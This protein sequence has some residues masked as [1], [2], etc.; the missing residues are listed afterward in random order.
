MN[1]I[2]STKRPMNNAGFSLV[3]L[4]VVVAI[5]GILASIAMPQFQ[6]FTFKARMTEAK[7]GLSSL[8][9]AEKAFYAEW[10]EYDSRFGAIG[11]AP[12]GNYYFNIGFGA[13]VA[14]NNFQ[15]ANNFATG[16]TTLPGTAPASDIHN[17]VSSYCSYAANAQRCRM[18]SAPPNPPVITGI[19]APSPAALGVVN[20]AGGNATFLAAASASAAVNPD[21]IAPNLAINHNKRLFANVAP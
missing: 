2:K 5:I 18:M 6:K 4:M 13:T 7:A 17:N 11:Y 21:N 14:S 15:L 1:F 20:A 3:E 12:E 16:S 19:T 8:Y 9:T 10:S